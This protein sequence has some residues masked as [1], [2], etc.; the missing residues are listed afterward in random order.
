M[1]L[2]AKMNPEYFEMLDLKTVEFRQFE[3]MV[4]ENSE[5]EERRE[6][7]VKDVRRVYPT[8][9]IYI[10]NKYPKVPWDRDL[11]IFAIELGDELDRNEIPVSVPL[12]AHSIDKK[13]DGKVFEIPE[14]EKTWHG[15]GD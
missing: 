5:T 7:R 4:L 10:K 2:Y 11:P 3:S 15:V 1:R 14:S 13:Q 9:E 6:F 8:S 12:P